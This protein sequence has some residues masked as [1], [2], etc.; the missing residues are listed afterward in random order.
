MCD[1]SRRYQQNLYTKIQLINTTQRT[2]YIRPLLQKMMELETVC[3]YSWLVYASLCVVT[4][5]RTPNYPNLIKLLPPQ[6][7]SRQAL[8]DYHLLYYRR[9][10]SAR[11]L[12]L[13]RPVKPH[14]LYLDFTIEITFAQALRASS[15]N[16]HLASFLSPMRCTRQA[17]V[18]MSV[19]ILH[20]S[21]T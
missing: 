13:P 8:Y 19:Y 10:T 5:S 15:L 6:M 16:E 3:E 2:K 7:A 21:L 4:L 12:L 11:S 17:F 20:V 9:I 14:F 18:L 1:H